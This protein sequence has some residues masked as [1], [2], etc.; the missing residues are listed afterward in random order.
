MNKQVDLMAATLKDD[1][2]FTV[3]LF[4][5]TYVICSHE[6]LTLILRSSERRRYLRVNDLLEIA[7]TIFFGS[8]DSGLNTTLHIT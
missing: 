5:V 3:E 4:C 2:Q 1:R 8:H 6:T 7:T